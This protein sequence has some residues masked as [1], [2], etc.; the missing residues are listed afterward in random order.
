VDQ[1]EYGGFFQIADHTKM[2]SY[3]FPYWNGKYRSDVKAAPDANITVTQAFDF[4]AKE[5]ASNLSGG[6][7]SF[8]MEIPEG[9]EAITADLGWS[10][11]F[12]TDGPGSAYADVRVG[13][14]YHGVISGVTSYY[15]PNTN[16]PSSSIPI[17]FGKPVRKELAVA[18]NSRNLGGVIVNITA[19]CQR[20]NEAYANWQLESFNAIIDAYNEKLDA[21]NKAMEAATK[22]QTVTELNP[23][24]YRQIENTVLRKNCIGYLV[25]DAQMGKKFY[26]GSTAMDISPL[27]TAEMDRYASMV[28]FIEQ[29]FEWEIMSYRFYPFYWG[30]RQEWQK[31]YQMEV[32]DPLFRSFL[33]SGMARVVVS[34]RPGFEEA[35][36]YF[37]ATGQIWNGGQ[38]PAIGDDLYLSIVEELKNPVYAIDETWETR[39][40]TTLTVIQA[41]SIG[42]DAQGLPCDCG[43]VTGIAN[44]NALLAQGGTQGGDFN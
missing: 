28:K 32:S 36:M 39:V 13:S 14:A 16:P 12:T 38:V 3:T 21:Y 23:G 18:V 31:N 43:N 2:D 33:Q 42:L 11:V 22:P 44:N 40:P 6:A 1:R 30:N 26:G 29:A 17:T 24:F 19:N 37:M 4:S 27:I 10:F 8:K 25:S 7:K 34:I 35:V 5:M 15:T 41:G 20:T 9:Y